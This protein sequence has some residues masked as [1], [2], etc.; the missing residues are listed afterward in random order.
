MSKKK[1]SAK[2]RLG[3]K[4]RRAKQRQVA[5]NKQREKDAIEE[6]EEFDGDLPIDEMDKSLYNSYN[7]YDA[8]VDVN[9]GIGATS[10]EELDI[11]R[12]E[13]EK[14]S[15]IRQ[16]TWD[17]EDLVRN[18]VNNPLADPKE[19]A[20]L[21]KKVGVDFG[22][23]VTTIMDTP[24]E[25]VMK[26]SVEILE[27][28]ALLARDKRQTGIVDK[29]I[30]LKK[31]S[32]KELEKLGDGAFALVD[33]DMRKYP[34]DS[35]KHVRESLEL[36]VKE[37]AK[38]D[39]KALETLP[40]V[41]SAA[42]S[43]GFDSILQEKSSLVVQKDAEG[44]WRWVGW[45]SNNFIDL[46]EDILT[47]AAHI[48]FV[49]WWNKSRDDAD[50]PVFTSFHAPGTARE[51]PVDFVAY[52]NGF[53]VMSGK[54]TT[55]E[56]VGLLRVQ[57]EYDLGMSHTGWGVRDVAD[58]RQIIKYRIYEVTDL[59]VERADNPFTDMAVISKEA[60]M[61]DKAQLEYLEKLLGSKEK[62][63][64]ALLMK[65]SLKKES[66]V[67]NGIEQKEAKGDKK[68]TEAAQAENTGEPPADFEA[69]IKAVG[70]KFDMDELSAYLAD[71]QKEVAKIPL[72]EDV[73]K[74]QQETIESLGKETDDQLADMLT[75]AVAP[76]AW[77][78]AKRASE[79]DGTIVPDGELEAL[80]KK[81]PGLSDDDWLSQATGTTPVKQIYLL[82]LLSEGGYDGCE[83]TTR[84]SID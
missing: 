84:K 76:Y 58:P 50:L 60:D 32:A 40:V 54:L 53:L 74:T 17:V 78:K 64:E 37:I 12:V 62:A 24:S 52:E 59:P 35:K 83:C 36:L 63:E 13:A 25:V 49:D 39:K 71:I 15:E 27:I 68:P 22:D 70:E 47:E 82:I 42:K 57:K 79:D 73:V 1:K 55:N 80:K 61:K 66:L 10:F 67:A 33:G 6:L 8:P 34:I 77:S 38:G 72:L 56:A 2:V 11:A 45:P 5:I 65:T 69:L 20:D 18:I 26:E 14:A 46:S 31:S 28:E 19:K 48:E 4:E 51:Y 16:T 44:D 75:P 23:R 29:L 30:R 9:R 41:R 3:E 81:A 43:T 7:V 21:I